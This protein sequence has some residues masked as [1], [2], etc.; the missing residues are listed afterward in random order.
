MINRSQLFREAHRI[1][2][3]ERGMYG[4]HETYRQAFAIAL[5]RLY[6]DRRKQL[7][8]LAAQPAIEPR[9]NRSTA[10]GSSVRNCHRTSVSFSRSSS[11]RIAGG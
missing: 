10:C 6:A 4:G 7:A 1:A 11:A 9:H 8:R 3:R 2:K 5:R